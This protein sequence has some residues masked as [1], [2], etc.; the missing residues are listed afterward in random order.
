MFLLRYYHCLLQIETKRQ[1]CFQPVPFAWCSAAGAGSHAGWASP[2]SNQ[3]GHSEEWH[4]PSPSCYPKTFHGSHGLAA[5]VRGRVFV[6]WAQLGRGRSQ[7]PLSNGC[8]GI[9]AGDRLSFTSR[10]RFLVMFYILKGSYK[11]LLSPEGSLTG[12]KVCPLFPL[13]EHL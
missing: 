6:L 12:C 13:P 9:A 7:Q 2:W 11:D 1:V 3:Q 8:G 4:Q 5:A 10:L